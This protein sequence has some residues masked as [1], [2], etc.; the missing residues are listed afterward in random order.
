MKKKE[1]PAKKNQDEGMVLI[2]VLAVMLIL[3]I[4]STAV[5]S[6]FTGNMKTTGNM[7]ARIHA[8]NLANTA[9]MYAIYEIQTNFD[10]TSCL[11]SPG[12]KPPASPVLPFV[13]YA[14]IPSS[15]LNGI[16]GRCSVAYV[17]NLDNPTGVTGMALAPGNPFFSY[18]S[19]IDVSGN[20][21][22]IL[23]QGESEGFKRTIKVSLKHTYF[24][25]AADSLINLT[26]GEL[27]IT[28]IENIT[29]L[30]P[31]SGTIYSGGNIEY[32]NLNSYRIHNGS[33]L[34]STGV[35]PPPGLGITIPDRFLVQNHSNVNLIDWSFANP[36]VTE[37]EPFNTTDYPFD[38]SDYPAMTVESFPTPHLAIPVPMPTP[39]IDRPSFQPVYAPTPAIEDD[40]CY[41][42]T[43]DMT[44]DT[45]TFING[46][47]YVNGGL[48]VKNAN[49]F[50]NGILIIVSTI[51]NSSYGNLYVTGYLN[52]P[53]ST[54]P[55][56]PYGLAMDVKV[57]VQ[58][59]INTGNEEGLGIFTHGDVRLGAIGMSSMYTMD[60]N[61]WFKISPLDTQLLIDTF[62]NLGLDRSKETE[63]QAWYSASMG[64]LPPLVAI[65]GKSGKEILQ[66]QANT[67]LVDMGL[68]PVP[69]E[70]STWFQ[71][72]Y[73][74]NSFTWATDDQ[75]T[76][77][78][79]RRN[80]SLYTCANDAFYQCVIY[81]HGTLLANGPVSP[82]SNGWWPVRIVGSVVATNNALY[83][84]NPTGNPAD[85]HGGII[86]LP[87]SSSIIFYSDYFISRSGRFLLEPVLT[88]YAWE[89]LY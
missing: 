35:I 2:S 74:D 47:L 60:T 70:V 42:H 88:V 24:T 3:L 28:G 48:K 69:D 23:A 54:N 72:S 38:N 50:V 64:S 13:V 78:T 46:S 4:F 7:S 15:K 49:L 29:T 67:E 66:G 18:I 14:P 19:S 31:S 75:V 68:A 62:E 45:D 76:W 5:V 58:G 10:V 83:S 71:S 63:I 30:A 77:N 17:N 22:V 11:W 61:E 51:D 25:S 87:G 12:L 32:D 56:Y 65:P 82:P 41:M 79:F 43:G 89:E 57:Q 21:A 44:V 27:L 40:E 8:L 37:G 52:D 34:C 53:N 73:V 9:C 1:V 84:P 55:D 16:S 81:T 39:G 26:H 86:D 33:T 36:T 59:G 20:G 6:L 80:P 85:S